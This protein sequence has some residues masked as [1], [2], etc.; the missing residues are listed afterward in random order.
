MGDGP[1]TSVEVP[2]ARDAS[3][4]HRVRASRA[5]LSMHVKRMCGKSL[6][7][8]E[9]QSAIDTLPGGGDG[10]LSFS[11]SPVVRR[12][13]L[14]RPQ[15]FDKG[16]LVRLRFLA[17]RTNPPQQTPATTGSELAAGRRNPV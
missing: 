2:E 5:T 13:A 14:R 4:I 3:S 11:D 17:Y 8:R 1:G 15:G 10:T 6:P 12:A 16:V 9:L 7:R